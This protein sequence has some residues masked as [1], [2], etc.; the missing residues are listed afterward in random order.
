MPDLPWDLEV[1]P[2]P[3]QKRHDSS[4][5]GMQAC[6]GVAQG[7]IWPDRWPIQVAVQVPDASI[8]LAHAGVACQ[9][10][11]GAGLAVAADPGVDQCVL[12]ILQAV[13]SAVG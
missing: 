10:R 5:G 9:M 13:G 1:M 7:Y 3:M 2:L 12:Q 11:L 4:K 8:G 6:Q